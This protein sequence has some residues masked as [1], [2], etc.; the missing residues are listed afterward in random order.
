M[1][2]ATKILNNTVMKTKVKDYANVSMKTIKRE[3]FVRLFCITLIVIANIVMKR[4][5]F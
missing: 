2:I 4:I 3:F 5:L 1:V